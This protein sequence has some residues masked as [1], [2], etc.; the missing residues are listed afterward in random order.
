M[1]KVVNHC[2]AFDFVEI[3]LDGKRER[4][5]WTKEKEE[6]YLYLGIYIVNYNISQRL[7]FRNDSD[8]FTNKFMQNIFEKS[9]L[10]FVPLY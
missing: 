10:Y 3:Y 1:E 2:S 6:N 7:I 9:H 5:G 8:K 4:E